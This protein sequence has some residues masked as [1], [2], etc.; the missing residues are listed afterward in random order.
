M[1]YIKDSVYVI[2]RDDRTRE[3]L[4]TALFRCSQC[5]APSLGFSNASGSLE[6]HMRDSALSP[7]WIPASAEGK[8]FPEVPGSR[9]ST[10]DEA[11]RCNSIQ[12]YRGAIALARA[13]LEATAKDQ[14]F[15]SGNLQKKIADMTA[16]GILRTSIGEAADQLRLAGNRVLHADD[17]SEEVEKASEEGKSNALWLLDEVLQEVYQSSARL[18]SIKQRADAAK[19]QKAAAEGA[20]TP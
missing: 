9:S 10:A 13:A 7:R 19:A 12:A 8:D 3:Y 16:K 6:E 20:D 5:R 11:H 14:D 15:T 18:A 1:E 17:A 2:S 4:I